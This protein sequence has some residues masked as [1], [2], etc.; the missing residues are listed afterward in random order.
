VGKKTGAPYKVIIVEMILVVIIALV[1]GLIWGPFTAAAV[2]TTMNGASLYV[3]HIIANFSLPV[4]GKRTLKAKVKEILPFAIFPLVAT[5]VYAFA[6][7]GVFIPVPTYPLNVASFW[8]V[9]II[10]S[11]I[12]VAV[13]IGRYRKKED[14]DKVG[15]EVVTSEQ[16]Q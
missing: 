16:L 1:G 3:V 7:Y 11:G 8:L 10:L 5:F 2:I 13:V 6:I 14:L 15:M 4:W 12:A 9:A